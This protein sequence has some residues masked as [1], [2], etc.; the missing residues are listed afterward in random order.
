MTK[1][2]IFFY[3]I[4]SGFSPFSH[5]KRKKSIAIHT[6]ETVRI[7]SFKG[8]IFG[9]MGL[10]HLFTGTAAAMLYVR[11]HSLEECLTAITGGALGGVICDVDIRTIN[12]QKYNS[13]IKP[14]TTIMLVKN[15]T[16]IILVIDALLNGYMSSY[17]RNADKSRLFQGIFLF[18]GLYLIGMFSRHRGF[19]HSILALF[20]FTY[21]V[22]YL[23][24][25]LV[26][27]FFIGYCSHIAIDLLNKKPVQLF[28][29]F[30][31]G[32]CLNLFYSN[33]VSDK[34]ILSI[35]ILLNCYILAD[36]FIKNDLLNWLK[37]DLPMSP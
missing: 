24:E 17:I 34:L 7:R 10:T 13:S 18:A 20:L 35:S 2:R 32:V 23:C 27:S 22:M 8:E 37:P 14:G 9:M 21:A 19:T 16:L 36:I 25:P 29:P 26:I 12:K 6:V 15:I 1:T 28:F 33:R 11:P 3:K 30:R 4:T 5:I 31:K